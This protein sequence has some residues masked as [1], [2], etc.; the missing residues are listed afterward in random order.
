M[1]I[2]AVSWRTIRRHAQVA[3]AVA[4]LIVLVWGVVAMIWRLLP[5]TTHDEW[6]RDRPLPEQPLRV[7]VFWQWYG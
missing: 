2:F 3:V 4:L 6:W 1:V 5:S 7:G